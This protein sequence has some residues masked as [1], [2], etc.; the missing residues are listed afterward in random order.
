[1]RIKKLPLILALAHTLVLAFYAFPAD[2]IPERLRF[3]SSTYTRPLFH[4]QWNLF[5]PD[6]PP[7]G[8]TIEVNENGEYI[9]L[10]AGEGL[11][12]R[13]LVKWGCRSMP[14]YKRT[15]SVSEQLVPW[16][17]FDL[18]VN[19]MTTGRQV[20]ECRV[21]RSCWIEEKRVRLIDKIQ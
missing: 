16:L 14:N 11:L 18:Y 21:V 4:Q 3:W 7:C 12:G 6:V 8:C 17:G 2:L 19:R 5:A 15:T 13:R 9:D 10:M 1:M 20:N